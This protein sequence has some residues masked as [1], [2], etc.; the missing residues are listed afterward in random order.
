MVTRI[1]RDWPATIAWVVFTVVCGA[2]AFFSWRWGGFFGVA[3]AVVAG[4]FALGAGWLA[5]RE[6][7]RAA[8]PG[9]DKPLG[10]LD[11]KVAERFVECS[12]CHRYCVCRKGEVSL[13]PEDFVAD[14]PFFKVRLPG[15]IRWPEVCCVCGSATTR[16]LPVSAVE[17]KTGSNLALGVGA[18][19]VGAIVVRTGGGARYTVE[20]PHCDAHTDGAKLDVVSEEECWV[21]FRSHA[22]WRAFTDL[23]HGQK[24]AS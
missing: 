5:L 22:Y 15:Q 2:G 17:S 6:S 12:A 14:A 7:G 19:A 21:H 16:A 24:L 11:A 9:C 8:C 4:F 10:G 18:L 1:Q 13:V 3:L 20:I 23:N